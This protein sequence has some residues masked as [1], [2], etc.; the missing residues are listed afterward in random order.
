MSDGINHR[1]NEPQQ[2]QSNYHGERD[3][4]EPPREPEQH[5]T[6]YYDYQ[7]DDQRSNEHGRSREGA[8]QQR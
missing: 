6:D 2:P 1:S 4:N 7:E 5:P 3:E 8:D